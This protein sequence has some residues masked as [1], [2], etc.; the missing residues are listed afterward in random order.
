VQRHERKK[1][2]S[3]T[4]TQ[5]NLRARRATGSFLFMKNAWHGM[6][7]TAGGDVGVKPA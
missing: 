2:F 6:A 7:A 5:L 4:G 1:E 3:T